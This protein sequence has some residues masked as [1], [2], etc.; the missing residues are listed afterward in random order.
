MVTNPLTAM[1][2]E[3]DRLGRIAYVEEQGLGAAKISSLYS[4]LPDG[5]ERQ[6]IDQLNGYI[7]AQHG[8]LMASSWPI[9]NKPCASHPKYI[10]MIRAPKPKRLSLEGKAVIC[11]RYFHPMGK[12]CFIAPP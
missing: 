12:N 1:M 3:I 9:V 5:S 8:Q 4:I 6:L 11:Q 10:S 2:P 7:Y